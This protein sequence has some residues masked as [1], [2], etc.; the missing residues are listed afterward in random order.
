M[1]ETLFTQCYSFKTLNHLK[2]T[3]IPIFQ[4]RK[5]KFREFCNFSK[6]IQLAKQAIS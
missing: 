6:M 5:L 4:M 3:I 1:C 2:K